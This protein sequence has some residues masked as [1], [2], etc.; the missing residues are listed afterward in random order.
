MSNLVTYIVAMTAIIML[1]LG[2][3]FIFLKIINQKKKNKILFFEKSKRR[4]YFGHM[5]GSLL[6]IILVF[7]YESMFPVNKLSTIQ[8]IS[9]AVLGFSFVVLIIL[10]VILAFI[11][12]WKPM[13][14]Q[15]NQ[16]FKILRIIMWIFLILVVIFLVFQF[17]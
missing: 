15:K 6:G 2:M 9:D 14:E 1:A 5:I 3:V 11:S 8:I 16:K 13:D 7:Y 12:H 10:G 17:S 4:F